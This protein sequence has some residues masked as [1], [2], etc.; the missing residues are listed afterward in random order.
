MLNF[1]QSN[2]DTKFFCP[3]TICVYNKMS[4]LS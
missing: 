3:L 1:L 4:D 2:I